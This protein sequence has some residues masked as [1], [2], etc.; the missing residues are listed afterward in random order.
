MPNIPDVPFRVVSV[1][2]GLDTGLA[3]MLAGPKLV[4]EETRVTH[5]QPLDGV[6]PLADL[7][8]WSRAHT[9]LPTVLVYEDFHARPGRVKPETTALRVLGGIEEWV[10]MEN[11]YVKIV[12]REPVQGKLAVTNEV[13]ERMGMLQ[14]GG[15]TR[16]ANDATR[17]AVAWLVSVGYLPASRM[18]WP[19]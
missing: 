5:Y 4:L 6:S 16:H 9:D 8:E 7:R 13:L 14:R 17:H 1:D 3:R 19:S 18:A 10:R 11:P 12:R 15:I 2:P